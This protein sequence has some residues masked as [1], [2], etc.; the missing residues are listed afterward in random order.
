[1]ELVSNFF[2]ME[3][4]IKENILTENLKEKEFIIGI[5]EQYIEVNLKTG[6]DMDVDNGNTQVKFTKETT[7]MT[8]DGERV[9]IIGT[10][11]IFIK[12]HFLMI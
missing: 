11:I 7:L 10:K 4:D 6:L 12:D 9:N 1:M 2:K 8:R 3:I 5:T